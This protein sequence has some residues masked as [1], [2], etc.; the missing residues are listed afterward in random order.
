[1]REGPDIVD[2]RSKEICCQQ[3]IHSES[4]VHDKAATCIP[5]FQ[6]H[7][8]DYQVKPMLEK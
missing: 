4:N 7:K 6:Q 5:D 1:M 3:Y 2:N 8:W